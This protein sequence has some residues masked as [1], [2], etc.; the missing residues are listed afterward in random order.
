MIFHFFRGEVLKH[1]VCLLSQALVHTVPNLTIQLELRQQYE[2][3]GLNMPRIFKMLKR[4][5]GR[6]ERAEKSVSSFSSMDWLSEEQ[7]V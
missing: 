6:G 4:G 7:R 1:W 3:V 5:E 2:C